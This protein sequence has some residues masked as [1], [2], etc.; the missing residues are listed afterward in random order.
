MVV[1]SSLTISYDCRYSSAALRSAPRRVGQH[2]PTRAY[3]P[4]SKEVTVVVLST[5]LECEESG[6]ERVSRQGDRRA[7]HRTG[8]PASNALQGPLDSLLPQGFVDRGVCNQ[9]REATRRVHPENI[10]VHDLSCIQPPPQALVLP[11][12]TLV[13]VVR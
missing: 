3:W 5:R 2:F 13:H 4:L 12:L 10:Q 9:R 6:T 11:P 7:P 8:E 1:Q